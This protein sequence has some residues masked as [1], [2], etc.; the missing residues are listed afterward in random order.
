[1]SEAGVLCRVGGQE[2]LQRVQDWGQ[3][4]VVVGRGKGVMGRWGAECGWWGVGAQGG[5]PGLGTM[6]WSGLRLHAVGYS[7]VP[8]SVCN[9]ISP[10]E[11][12]IQSDSA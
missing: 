10:N 2:E 6:Y 8:S 11:Q 3:R 4:S 5:R 9:Y 7:Q 12:V 1:M